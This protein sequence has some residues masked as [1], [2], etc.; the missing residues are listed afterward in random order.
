MSFS[1]GSPYRIRVYNDKLIWTD[2]E[3]YHKIR[4]ANMNGT[5]ITTITDNIENLWGLDIDRQHGY[6]KISVHVYRH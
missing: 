6:V 5:S 2:F 4:S 3:F 1:S